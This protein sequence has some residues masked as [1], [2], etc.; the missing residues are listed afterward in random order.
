[1]GNLDLIGLGMNKKVKIRLKW[2]RKPSSEPENGFQFTRPARFDHQ[3]EDWKH[4]AWSL[5]V[6]VEGTPDLKSEQVGTAW[7]LVDNAPHD[8]LTV[9]KHFALGAEPPFAE[10]VVEQILT[11]RSNP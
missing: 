10:G 11:E 9:G 4:N 3:G 5:V 7:F 2:L 1:M 6:T 8:W